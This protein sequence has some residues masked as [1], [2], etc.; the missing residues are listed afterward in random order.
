MGV[1]NLDL[2]FVEPNK[3]SKDAGARQYG[4]EGYLSNLL[5]NVSLLEQVNVQSLG[6]SHSTRERKAHKQ[7][8]VL[9]AGR[10]EEWFKRGKPGS[11]A[12][13]LD[14]KSLGNTP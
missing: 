5:V 14:M 11:V 10:P 3:R 7:C 1:I 2:K 8:S 9:I 6:K 12:F 13:R 4:K